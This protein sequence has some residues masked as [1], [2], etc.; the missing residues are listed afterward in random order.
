M[1]HLKNDNRS[2]NVGLCFCLYD[3]EFHISFD[4][5][6]YLFPQQHSC[7]SSFLFR[8]TSPRWKNIILKMYLFTFLNVRWGCLKQQH[9]IHIVIFWKK[10][11]FSSI[12]KLL[13]HI[14]SSGMQ[15]HRPI[16]HPNLY[17]LNH[18]VITLY[19]MYNFD[20][21]PRVICSEE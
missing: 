17:F 4:L 5:D 20:I 3:I 19:C 15:R 6:I 1:D 9:R 14:V 8:S 2:S 16:Q 7:F 11:T 10:E 18:S 12:M 13:Y 21:K